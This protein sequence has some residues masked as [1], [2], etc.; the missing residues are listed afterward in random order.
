MY[1]IVTSEMLA[2]LKNAYGSSMV[3][4]IVIK[5]QVESETFYVLEPSCRV[6]TLSL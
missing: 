1:A 2:V 6:P 3:I 4:I 5:T